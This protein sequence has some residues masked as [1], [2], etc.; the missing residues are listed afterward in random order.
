[1]SKCQKAQSIKSQIS[2]NSENT[3][4]GFSIFEMSKIQNV[5]NWY[6]RI[7]FSTF[8]LF[9]KI[10]KKIGKH[11]I[12]K[13]KKVEK[14]ISNFKKI[15]FDVENFQGFELLAFLVF[16]ILT[17]VILPPNSPATK[18]HQHRLFLSS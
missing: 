5:K 10:F 6:G 18:R 1:M 11:A 4:G 15:H 9:L 17:F 12:L 2:V 14:I 16:D 13:I 7:L 3:I 8:R